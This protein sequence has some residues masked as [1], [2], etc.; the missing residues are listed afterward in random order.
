MDQKNPLIEA[1]EALLAEESVEIE[2][3][4]L[5][6][7]LVPES[8]DEIEA[9][10]Q[11]LMLRSQSP[12]QQVQVLEPQDLALPLPEGPPPSNATSFQKFGD[13]PQH[14][15]EHAGVDL[16]EIK[17]LNLA[18]S[19]DALERAAQAQ[20]NYPSPDAGFAVASLSEQ[21]LKLTKDLEKSQDP[22]KV[23]DLIM[24]DVLQEMTRDMIHALAAEM[25]NLQTETRALVQP[26]KMD[27]YN[28]AFGIAVNR[29]GP[30]MKDLLEVTKSRL[31][32]SLNIKIKKNEGGHG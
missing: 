6:E 17:R 26:E 10:P 8:E 28:L 22:Q 23:M 19:I 5:V 16:Y 25:K 13:I 18:V 3:T 1:A 11:A 27:A 24:Q 30:A 29:M 32:R 21:I 14:L 31:A 15:R 20:E 7:S 12:Q 2:T 4:P 9:V